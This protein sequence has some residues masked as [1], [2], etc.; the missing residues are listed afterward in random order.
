[1]SS[2]ANFSLPWKRFAS[3]HHDGVQLLHT[4]QELVFDWPANR[5]EYIL[6]RNERD[7]NFQ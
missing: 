4:F 2:T 5:I 3:P 1:M 7:R 6:I